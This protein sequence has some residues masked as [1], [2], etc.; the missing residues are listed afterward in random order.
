MPQ[1]V[2][3]AV[4]KT[5]EALP[6]TGK[7][8][9]TLASMAP[10]VL[11]GEAAT[12]RSDIWALGVVLYEMA[13]GAQPFTGTTQTDVVS[14]I[15]KESP[16]PLPAKVS[17]GLRNVIQHCLTKEPARRYPHP[18]AIQS[19]LETIQSDRFAE[20]LTLDTGET[21]RVPLPGKWDR[22]RHLNLSPNERWLAYVDSTGPRGAHFQPS[23]AVTASDSTSTVRS[24]SASVITT[25]G[26]RT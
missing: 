10:E 9:G 6:H 14:A 13:S 18:S 21:R 8:V 24:I 12:A 16:A 5:Q 1:A 3:E 17:P 2:A 20:I 23:T 4:T 7:L 25:G 15:V 26:A 19:A 22:R 11:R